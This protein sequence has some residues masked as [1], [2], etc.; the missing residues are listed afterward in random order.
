MRSISEQLV[1]NLSY[2]ENFD[3]EK[4]KKKIFVLFLKVKIQTVCTKNRKIPLQAKRFFKVMIYLPLFI[5]K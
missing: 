3:L 5:K 2:A 4:L 1:N